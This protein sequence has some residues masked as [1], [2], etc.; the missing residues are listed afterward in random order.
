MSRMVTRSPD[1]GVPLPAPE[2]GK[3]REPAF[4]W[5]HE[6]DNCIEYSVD[7]NGYGSAIDSAEK[8]SLFG[9]TLLTVYTTNI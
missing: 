5:E 7:P 9:G 6:D 4:A 8:P 2:H 3:Y 1:L